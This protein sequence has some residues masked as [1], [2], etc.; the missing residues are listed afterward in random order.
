[1]P[2][3]SPSLRTD[4]PTCQV[5][6]SLQA[7]EPAWR[8]LEKTGIGTP[9]QRFDWVKSWHDA[10]GGD[11]D[12]RFAVL[13]VRD[14]DGA[15]AALLPVE[16]DRVGPARVARVAG[17]R[18]ANFGMPML[19]PAFAR[20]LS[21]QDAEALLH[22]L[23]DEHRAID[24]FAFAN[25]PALC[26]GVPNPFAALPDAHPTPEPACITVIGD[27]R[28][29]IVERTISK[30]SR[31]K[32]AKKLRW[33]AEA[34]PVVHRK[35]ATE[36]EVDLVLAAFFRQ[37]A[38]RCATRQLPDPF[39]DGAVR[40][41]VRSTCLAGLSEGQ[42]AVELHALFCA[43][44]PV[45]VMGLAG[46]GRWLSGSFLSHE[47]EPLVERCSPG[48]LLIA[49]VLRDAGRR[50]YE[51]FDLGVGAAAYKSSFCK[52]PL[53]MTDTYLPVSWVGQAAAPMLAGSGRLRAAIK[54]DPRLMALVRHVT[55]YLP[56]RR[57]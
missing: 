27:E 28:A 22:R 57:R 1:M 31:K 53:A 5:Y 36:G 44:R 17:G 43:D 3:P 19:D 39:A 24:V 2:Q 9:Y 38:Q 7:A 26:A 47:P 21:P 35:A 16:V 50:G 42:P 52:T 29:A 54:R 13:M 6:R 11:E 34:G 37:K 48:E 56:A 14:G 20:R 25:Q 41:F 4:G 10:Q 40:F 8:A 32:F 55:P 46:D 45:A 18:H 12:G 15:P 49:E 30:E 23:A 33:L 51:V